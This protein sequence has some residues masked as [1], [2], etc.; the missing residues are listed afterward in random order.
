M[1]CNVTALIASD[2]FY[3][4]LFAN[5]G[6]HIWDDDDHNDELFLWYGRLLS[7]HFCLKQ[8]FSLRLSFF[9]VY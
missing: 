4:I 5:K 6:M 1:F 8:F 7:K 2:L 9:I 3:R